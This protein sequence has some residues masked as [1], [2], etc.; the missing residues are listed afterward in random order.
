MIGVASNAL[1]VYY[2]T[3]TEVKAFFGKAPLL[4]LKG[5]S[6]RF[7]MVGRFCV[8]CGN[9]LNGKEAYCPNCGSK[10]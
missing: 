7:S 4:E 6:R 3:R 5:F 9:R 10:P 1:T 2:L 8:D